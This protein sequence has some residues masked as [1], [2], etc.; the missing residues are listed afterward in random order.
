MKGFSRKGILGL[1]VAGLLASHTAC[2]DHLNRA[3]HELEQAGHAVQNGNN[4]RATRL[5][6]DAKQR[7]LDRPNH[8]LGGNAAAAVQDLNNWV[9]GNGE[10][11]T[12]IQ[13]LRTAKEVRRQN[14]GGPGYDH[15]LQ[16]EQAVRAAARQQAIGNTASAQADV[17]RAIR[18][19]ATRG[20]HDLAGNAQA[21]QQQLQ[22]WTPGSDLSGVVNDFNS[23]RQI[24]RQH[25]Q[26]Y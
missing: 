21:A 19:D 1:L 6:D 17:N 26:G 8:Q 13:D 14:N 7:L 9:P 18:I 2:A 15:L 22:N 3:Q 11:P 4:A 24:R 20:R 23:A 16:A 25:N 10:I 12:A 5:V